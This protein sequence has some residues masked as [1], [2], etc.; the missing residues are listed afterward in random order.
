MSILPANP[1]IVS[2]QPSGTLG[3]ATDGGLSVEF[4]DLPA[5]VTRQSALNLAGGI[6]SQ[7]LKFIA[8]IFIARKFSTAEFGVF[9]F[10]W[11]VNAILLLISQFG[12]PTFGARQVACS[13]VVAQ[14]LTG[15]IFRARFLLAFASTVSVLLLLLAIAPVS[16]TELWLV[17]LF[18]ISNMAQAGFIDWAFQ[19]LGKFECS[20]VLNVTFQA[21]WLILLFF[22]VRAGGDIRAA[23]SALCLAAMFVTGLGFMWLR[24]APWTHAS[25]PPASWRGAWETLKSASALG[26]G[27]LLINLIVWTDAIWVRVLHGD[28]AVGLYA[29]GNRAAL[30]LSTLATFF[31]QGAFPLLSRASAESRAAFEHCLERTSADLALLYVPGSLW[32]IYYA[33]EIINLIFHR[34]DYLAAVPLFRI[35]QFVLLLF[36]ANTVLGTGVLAAFHLD[37][38]FRNVLAGTAVAFLLLCPLLTWR[39]GTYGAASAMAVSQAIS[40][41][42]FYQGA[43]TLVPFHF[44]R[45]L[46]FPG[47]AGISTIA[48][49]HGLQLSMLGGTVVLAVAYLML[50]MNRKRTTQAR[51]V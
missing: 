45:I 44:V 2:Q 24:R 47:V 8:L 12:L 25:Q 21:L 10:A 50:W 4:A 36:V 32:A 15:N 1:P 18:G 3:R 5:H 17:V 46:I 13:G 22:T 14:E 20:L 37:N 6:V 34:A 39:W 51:A 41:I 28:V 42:W 29:A 27:A 7:G 43:R 40:L 11:A 48:I 26:T 49:C 33:N 35:F 38:S 23:G 16:R 30:A 9:S 19:G 31:V